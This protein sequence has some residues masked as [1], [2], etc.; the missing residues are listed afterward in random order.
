MI[1]DEPMPD[2]IAG[3]SFGTAFRIALCRVVIVSRRSAGSAARNSSTVGSI[4]GMRRA[5]APGA[6]RSNMNEQLASAAS[7]RRVA[8]SQMGRIALSRASKKSHEIKSNLLGYFPS[9]D[10]ATSVAL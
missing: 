5:C 6:Q 1:G 3:A 4:L 10:Q 8:R 7:G 2:I 9:E